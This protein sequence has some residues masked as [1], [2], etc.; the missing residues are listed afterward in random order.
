MGESKER[1]KERKRAKESKREQ[2]R[3]RKRVKVML[4]RKENGGNIYDVKKE[5]S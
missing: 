4:G 3:E 5:N 2:K 1:E